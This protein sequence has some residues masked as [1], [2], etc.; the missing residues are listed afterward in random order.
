MLAKVW[1]VIARNPARAYS[2]VLAVIAL[3]ASFGLDLTT[4]QLGALVALL[5]LIF[6][7]TVHTQVSPSG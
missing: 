1:T 4:E 6:G 5:S 2:I 7:Q 3:A